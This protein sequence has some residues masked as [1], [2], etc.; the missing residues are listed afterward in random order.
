[1]AKSKEV[2]GLNNYESAETMDSTEAAEPSYQ[3]KGAARISRSWEGIKSGFMNIAR[4]VKTGAEVAAA[5]PEMVGDA[6]RAA[7]ERGGEIKAS[8]V[9]RIENATIKVGEPIVEAKARVVSAATEKYRSL[10]SRSVNA[11]EGFR[12]RIRKSKE[13]ARAKI[14]AMK[15]EKAMQEYLAAASAVDQVMARFN[16]AAENAG[17][18]ERYRKD[19]GYNIDQLEE[20]A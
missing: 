6:L 13:A 2:L 11:Y 7:H 14:E 1:M 3:D 5:T 4:K 18:G 17:V 20:A 19:G 16:R 10:E 9:D 8:I 15:K 12:A